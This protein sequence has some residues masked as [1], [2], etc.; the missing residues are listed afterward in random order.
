MKKLLIALVVLGLLG[1][2]G[3]TLLMRKQPAAPA[4]QRKQQTTPKAAPW[5]GTLTRGWNMT[6]VH[7]GQQLKFEALSF[8]GLNTAKAGVTITMTTP[9]PADGQP[10]RWL[11]VR[12]FTVRAADGSSWSPALTAAA[13]GDEIVATLTVAGL[14]T[15]QL[16]DGNVGLIASTPE[17]PFSVALVPPPA[18]D[19]HSYNETSQQHAPASSV[20]AGDKVAPKVRLSLRGAGKHRYVLVVATDNAKLGRLLVIVDGR[21]KRL[22]VHDGRTAARVPVAPGRHSLRARAQDT[23]GNKS[24]V[25]RLLVRRGAK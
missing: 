9:K 23:A 21:R 15:E 16:V 1:I 2:T 8:S 4:P 12:K 25:A 14:P 18:P 24:T 17:G 13:S 19:G 7:A 5:D 22:P 20:A 3:Y 10:P 11:T 6:V